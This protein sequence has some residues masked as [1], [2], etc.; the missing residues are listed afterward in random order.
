MCILITIFPKTVLLY[1]P[2]FPLRVI[3]VEITMMKKIRLF[4]SP[5]MFDFT[6]VYNDF[7]NKWNKNIF[8]LYYIRYINLI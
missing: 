7:I 2:F 3:F 8:F 5:F 1:L 4:Y 6:I